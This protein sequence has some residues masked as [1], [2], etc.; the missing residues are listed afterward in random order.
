MSDEATARPHFG[1]LGPTRQCILVNS[2]SAT[3][4]GRRAQSATTPMAPRSGGP[5]LLP[6]DPGV[7]LKVRHSFPRESMQHF[8]LGEQLIP[9]AD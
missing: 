7:A 6:P 9:V 1:P 4:P 8:S 2:I 5:P 3:W